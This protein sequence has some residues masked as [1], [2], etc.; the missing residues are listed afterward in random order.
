M[1]FDLRARKK[2]VEG[3]HMGAFSWSWMLREGVGAVVGY[4]PGIEPSSF[5]YHDR[6]DGRCVAYNDGAIVSAKEAKQMAFLARLLAQKED[7]INAHWESTTDE[8]RELIEGANERHAT[9]KIYKTPVRRDFVQNVRSFADW[10]EKSG[11][12]RVY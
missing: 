9:Y 10:A 4:F 12:F 2:G 7:T 5:F 3:F 1:G 6:K 8:Y 11:G